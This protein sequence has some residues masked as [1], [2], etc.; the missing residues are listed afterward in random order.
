MVVDLRDVDVG[1]A[2]AG[3][4]VQV[5]ASSAPLPAPF[6]S[7]ELCVPIIPEPQPALPPCAAA[8]T[9][10]GAPFRSRARSAV[11]TTSGDGAVVLLA[12]VVEAQRRGDHAGAEVVGERHRPPVHDG[13]RVVLRM[14]ATGQRDLG[15]LLRPDAEIVQVA[16]RHRRE[17]DGR[18][19]HAVGAI[20]SICGIS[21]K[22]PASP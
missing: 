17:H 6:A 4:R 1:G 3:A 21:A 9:R 11:V 7:G 2:D 5:L 8:R 18:G 13:P 16:L 22:P 20:R 10:T 12:A 14:R 19:Q 15:E